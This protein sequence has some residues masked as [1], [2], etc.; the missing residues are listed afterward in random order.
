MKTIAN[1]INESKQ[2]I[3]TTDQFANWY[4]DVDGGGAMN[5]KHRS[6]IHSILEKQS[7]KDVAVDIAYDKLS[8][9]DKRNIHEIM[10]QY[11]GYVNES[12]FDLKLD[13]LTK[14]LDVDMLVL[15]TNIIRKNVDNFNISDLT[16]TVND[17]QHKLVQESNNGVMKIYVAVKYGKDK[18]IKRFDV[19]VVD[20]LQL[21]N[22]LK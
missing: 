21:S 2:T 10:V 22:R 19:I 9:K 1:F 15:A 13:N 18:W 16:F 7:S 5:E 6:K 8:D 4:D 20:L 12:K 14:T 17:V 3:L 11:G